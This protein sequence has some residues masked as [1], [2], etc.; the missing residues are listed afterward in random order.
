LESDFA[1]FSAAEAAYL[2]THNRVCGKL[3]AMPSLPGDS[4]KIFG[5]MRIIAEFA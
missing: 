2:R 5:S 1:D 3:T 4:G